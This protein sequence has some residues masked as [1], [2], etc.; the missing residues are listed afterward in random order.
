MKETANWVGAGCQKWVRGI[1]A[2]IDSQYPLAFRELVVKFREFGKQDL[3]L[4]CSLP[5]TT[6]ANESMHARF[7]LMASK[8]KHHDLARLQ[9]AGDQVMLNSNF[10]LQNANLDSVFG[11]RSTVAEHDLAVSQRQ[12]H[13]V[14]ERRHVHSVTVMDGTRLKRSTNPDTKDKRRPGP[15]RLPPAKSRQKSAYVGGGQAD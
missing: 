1:F 12:S 14:A 7:H 3:M 13:R 10:G 4:R 5:V 11:T 8:A 2:G 15:E 9:F 6:N